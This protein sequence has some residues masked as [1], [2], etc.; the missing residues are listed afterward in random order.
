M[1]INLHNIEVYAHHG[2]WE[3]E[4]VIGGRYIVDVTLDV[5]FKEAA[6]TDDLTK[7]VDYCVVSDVVYREMAIRS[8]LIETVAYRI[9]NALI[10][11]CPQATK[12]WVRITKIAA[13]IPRQ[14]ESV[15]VE[16][17]G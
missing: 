5:D 7:T 14:V 10:K 12:R 11:E 13:P 9:L 1:K 4:A 17:E 3:E 16:V 8:K 2:C 6:A 15:S